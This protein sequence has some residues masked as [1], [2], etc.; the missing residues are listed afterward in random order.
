MLHNNKYINTIKRLTIRV[1]KIVTTVFVVWFSIFWAENKSAFQNPNITINGASVLSEDNYINYL[2]R[3]GIDSTKIES[4]FILESLYNHPYVAAA[5]I[6][7]RYPNAIIIDISERLPF[8]MLNKDPMV[9]LD[10]EC[11]VLPNIENINDYNIPILSKYN[12]APEL[13]PLGEQSL[14]V[15]I[16][17]TISWL[18]TLNTKYPEIYSEI[19]EITLASGDEI[20]LILEKNPTK[21]MLGNKNTFR[22]LEILKN[23]KN[24]L[25]NKKEIT[26]YVYLDMRY[27]NQIIAKEL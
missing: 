9:I 27:N 12:A 14:S 24:T 2:K 13:Y 21:I 20:I 6:S 26:D 25:N 8:A 23:F 15:K 4:K 10:R 18:K 22:K 11:Y 5:R 1:I 16:K 7:H 17:H 19:S 3:L